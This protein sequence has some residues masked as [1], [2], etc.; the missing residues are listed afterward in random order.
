M[1]PSFTPRYAL[2]FGEVSILHVGGKELGEGGRRENGFTVEE[3]AQICEDLLSVGITTNHV[4]LSD[5][6]PEEL[7]SAHAASV[8][9]IR[10]GAALFCGGDAA[11]ADKML[12]E[13]QSIPYD[14]KFWNARQKKTMH[15]RA[16]YN[17]TFA[18]HDVAPS[19]DFQT[20]STHAF[21]PTLAVFRNE[22]AWVLG[23]KADGLSAEGNHYFEPN[24]G[25]GYHGDAERK[26]VICL[27]L[28]G[29]SVLRYHWRMPGSSEHTL[30]PVDI[31]V[32]HGDVYVMSEKA[33]GFDWKCRSRVRVVHGA[34]SDKYIKPRKPRAAGAKR[35]RK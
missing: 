23:D 15:K 5:A 12:E 25:I 30:S 10:N 28:G 20:P 18:E 24:S 13:Q 8:L 34:G 7:Q 22:L 26:I 16:R 35:K 14:K 32:S 2:T 31:R 27:S 9:V 4:V 29:S 17:T 21:P 33:T 19:E 1:L 11:A 3:L 6:L